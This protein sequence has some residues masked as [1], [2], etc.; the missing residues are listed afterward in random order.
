MREIKATLLTVLSIFLGNAYA[1]ELEKFD[2]INVSIHDINKT[3][4]MEKAKLELKNLNFQR[5]KTD[6]NH[7]FDNMIVDN[8]NTIRKLESEYKLMLNSEVYAVKSGKKGVN[9]IE[10]PFIKKKVYSLLLTDQNRVEEILAESELKDDKIALLNDQILA[11]GKEIALLNA[12]IL[13]IFKINKLKL[14]KS[15]ELC[16]SKISKLKKTLHSFTSVNNAPIEVEEEVVDT[17]DNTLIIKGVNVSK[18]FA[19]GKSVKITLSIDYIIPLL[20]DHI[21]STK[22]FTMSKQKRMLIKNYGN[23]LIVPEADYINF[24]VED[25]LLHKEKY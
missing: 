15:K 17:E 21:Q 23:I 13:D 19:M 11:L 9:E 22:E 2:N 24:Y 5:Y 25:R 4:E 16:D 7:V 1:I 8:N 10:S 14:K 20:S 12:N 3:A 6:R 18:K